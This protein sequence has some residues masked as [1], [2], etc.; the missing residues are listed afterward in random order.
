M[1]AVW[2]GG[3]THGELVVSGLSI[4]GCD[5]VDCWERGGEGCHHGSE[6]GSRES[7]CALSLEDVDDFVLFKCVDLNL[8]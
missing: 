6:D 8:G 4:V 2:E 7:H 3:V 5:S 1:S